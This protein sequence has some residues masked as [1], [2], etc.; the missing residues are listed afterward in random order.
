LTVVL[1]QMQDFYGPAVPLYS[2]HYRHS[3]IT[4][5]LN[6]PAIADSAIVVNGIALLQG[7]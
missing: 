6:Q 7:G 1:P 5:G 2:G 3:G 4:Y